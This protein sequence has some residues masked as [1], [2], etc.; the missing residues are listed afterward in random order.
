MSYE[1]AG[2]VGR[3]V[4]FA[5]SCPMQRSKQLL[6]EL[7][8]DQGLLR[9]KCVVRWFHREEDD[10]YYCSEIHAG[11]ELATLIQSH[12]LTLLHS[13]ST[14]YTTLLT[15]PLNHTATHTHTHTHIFIFEK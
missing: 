10:Y 12:Q 3:K 1:K 2:K 6:H 13:V 14:L 9:R 11:S 4:S 5:R 8:Q 7:L 15:E